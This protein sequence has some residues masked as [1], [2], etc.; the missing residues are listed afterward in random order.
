MQLEEHQPEL[1]MIRQSKVGKTAHFHCLDD[2]G[3]LCFEEAGLIFKRIPD[4]P[5]NVNTKFL[6]F[7]PKK[8]AEPIVLTPMSDLTSLVLDPSLPLKIIV[9][10][11]K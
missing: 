3:K 11:W 9:H 4:H 5:E 1:E 6:V 10:G 8:P 7:T 2:T